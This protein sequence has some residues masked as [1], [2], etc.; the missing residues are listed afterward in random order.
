MTSTGFKK[1]ERYVLFPEYL[2][3]ASFLAPKEDLGFGKHD[4]SNFGGDV[5]KSKK[6]W[7]FGACIDSRCGG[8]YR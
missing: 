1:L 7:K 3:M 6:G 8:A 2:D 5:V 4:K